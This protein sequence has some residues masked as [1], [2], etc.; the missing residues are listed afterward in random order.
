VVEF[1]IGVGFCEG[2]ESLLSST[3]LITIYYGFEPNTECDEDVGYN[4]EKSC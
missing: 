1:R 3:V 4:Q 2:M